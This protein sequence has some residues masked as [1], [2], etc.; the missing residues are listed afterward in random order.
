VVLALATPTKRAIHYLWAVL[1]AR[2]YEVFPL[3]CPICGGQMRLIAF[4]TEGTQI[5]RILE[6]VGVD[7]EPPHMALVRGPSWWD[8]CS[9]V[10][11][12]AE[13]PIESADWDMAAQPAFAQ[14][15]EPL[16]AR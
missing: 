8:D 13:A 7:S 12:D 3:L 9:D 5:R 11:M 10:Q 14:F 2:V 6:H 16:R 1:I 4:I 15:G